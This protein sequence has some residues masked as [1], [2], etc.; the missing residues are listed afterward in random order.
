MKLVFDRIMKMSVSNDKKYNRY[1][2]KEHINEEHLKELFA[3]NIGLRCYR[4]KRGCQVIDYD[5]S[6]CT[7]DRLNNT[8]G[9]VKGN[10]VLSCRQCNFKIKHPR[11]KILRVDE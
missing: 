8:I 9:H 3:K 10:C 5:R 4:C 1:N 7:I 2:E 11:M 6:L